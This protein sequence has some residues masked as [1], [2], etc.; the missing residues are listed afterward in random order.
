MSYLQNP[1]H[2]KKCQILTNIWQILKVWETNLL[3]LS[4]RYLLKSNHLISDIIIW[5]VEWYSEHKIQLYAATFCIAEMGS[6]T[7]THNFL[8]ST[9]PTFTSVDHTINKGWLPQMIIP[10][11]YYQNWADCVASYHVNMYVTDSMLWQAVAELCQA[12]V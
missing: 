4:R 11:I 10:H 6:W 8:K 3:E 12:Q 1:T 9:D 2:S 5:Y 7:N